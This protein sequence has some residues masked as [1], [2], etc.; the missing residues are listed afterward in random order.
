MTSQPGPAKPNQLAHDLRNLLTVIAAQAERLSLALTDR[1]DLRPALEAVEEAVA[2][3]GE[4]THALAAPPEGHPLHA[5][6]PP[7][8]R[9]LAAGSRV[10]LVE[11]DRQ[12]RQVVAAMLL[13]QGLSVSQFASANEALSQA[14]GGLALAVLDTGLTD[15]PVA[16]LLSGL[17]RIRPGLPAVFVCGQPDSGVTQLLDQCTRLLD[18]PFRAAELAAVVAELLPPINAES[19]S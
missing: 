5:A 19:P 18:K 16:Q 6:P 2:R 7:P 10:L 12:V 1:P 15:R 17:R 11:S 9:K 4:L 8:P 13:T 3:A 14:D